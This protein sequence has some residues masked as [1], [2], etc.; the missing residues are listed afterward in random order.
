MYT[1]SDGASIESVADMA[2]WYIYSVFHNMYWSSRAAR[3]SQSSQWVKAYNQIALKP[4][5]PREHTLGMIGFGDVGFA[6][7]KKGQNGI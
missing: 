3:S 6:I 7:A 2:L 1:F 5:N 4:D